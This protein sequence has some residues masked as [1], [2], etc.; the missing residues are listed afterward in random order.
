[1]NKDYYSDF[2]E[3]FNNLIEEYMTEYNAVVS[4]DAWSTEDL[5]ALYRIATDALEY[6]AGEYNDPMY[7]YDEDD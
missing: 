1:M 7:M 2:T 3:E 6:R 4:F 5:T